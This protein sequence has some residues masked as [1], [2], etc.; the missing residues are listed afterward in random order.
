MLGLNVSVYDPVLA[1][2][3]SGFAS[4]FVLMLERAG[5][6]NLKQ[7]INIASLIAVLSLANTRIYIC[8]SDLLA[9]SLMVEPGIV[10]A[11]Q[12]GSSI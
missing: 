2:E 12:G 5:L 7:V 6:T 10:R 4:P 9:N 8:V 11:C 3:T 1:S